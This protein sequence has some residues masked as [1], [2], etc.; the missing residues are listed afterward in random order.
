M[1]AIRAW[2]SEEKDGFVACWTSPDT[3]DRPPATHRFSSK[4]LARHWIYFQAEE[5][6]C[7]VQWLDDPPV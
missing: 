2:I 4:D 6:G 3:L 1:H 7:R 5:L